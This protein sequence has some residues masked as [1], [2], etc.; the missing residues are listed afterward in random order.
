MSERG[1]H[2]CLKIYTVSVR[3]QEIRD[4]GD[5]VMAAIKKEFETWAKDGLSMHASAAAHLDFFHG[6]SST[7]IPRATRDP[8]FQGH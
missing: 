1:G 7:V 8:S 4:R 2:L 6:T 3:P 5:E